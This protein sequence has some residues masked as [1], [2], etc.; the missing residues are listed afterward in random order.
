ME[1]TVSEV[2]T[3]LWI[4]L[5]ICIGGICWAVIRMFEIWRNEIRIRKQEEV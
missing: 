1:L 3:C 4:G 5:F 2:A